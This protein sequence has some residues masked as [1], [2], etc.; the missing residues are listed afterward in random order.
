MKQVIG[1]W[2]SWAFA[3]GTM[4]GSGI[5]LLPSV[6]APFGGLTIYAWLL[7]AAGTLLIILTLGSLSSAIGKEGGPYAYC[8]EVMGPTP[9][10]LIGW[11]HW[12][13]AW[14]AVAAS[15]I[16]FA[17]YAS[18][19][20][21]S[22]E[23]SPTLRA[24]ISISMVWILGLI[25]ANG[26]GR[27]SAT[28]IISTL[29]KAVPLLLIPALGFMLGKQPIEFSGPSVITAS[30]F[31]T[32]SKVVLITMWVFIGAEVA[33][34]PAE[35]TIDAKKTIPRALLLG[36]ATV[37][38]V[39]IFA[40]FGIWSVLPIDQLSHSSSPFADSAELF[41][42]KAGAS[43]VAI[44]IMISIFGSTNGCM[45]AAI[46]I[47]KSM[48]RDGLFPSLF[49]EMN[50]NDVAWKSLLVSLVLVTIVLLLHASERLVRVYEMLIILSTLATLLPYAACA[51]A[52]LI[53]QFKI[54]RVRLYSPSVFR[55][56]G[57]LV[58]S[59][60]MICGAGIEVIMYGVSLLMIG[61][62]TYLSLYRKPRLRKI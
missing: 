3:V 14:V 59:V 22:I 40:T 8:L 52:D 49:S 24:I 37:T 29:L 44:A 38:F 48:S 39:Y 32:I 53:L 10:F 62:I 35:Q 25:F 31:E 51:I 6:L 9:A 33:T 57:A 4:T 50:R 41:F 60:F 42:G 58:F 54:T 55:A 11:G 16:A 36:L 15:S 13:S 27:V 46:I 7:T 18:C 12:I 61:L 17:G 56:I 19:L 34:I 45:V 28:Q 5:F 47:P 23:Q 2:Q 21:P 43:L 26:I 30:S 20:F 1:L